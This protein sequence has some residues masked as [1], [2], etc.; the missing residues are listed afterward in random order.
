MAKLSG[1]GM[2]DPE[3]T[4]ASLAPVVEGVLDAFGPQRVMWGSNFPVD[5]LYRPYR[6]LFEALA[7]LVPEPM[8]AAIFAG[9]ARRF[10]RL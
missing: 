6:E 7:G 3:W 10:Y 1:L 8:H 4:A 2:F 9:T 5:K